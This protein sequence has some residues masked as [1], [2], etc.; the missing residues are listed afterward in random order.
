MCLGIVGR[1]EFARLTIESAKA[2]DPLTSK[3]DLDGI[4]AFV[5]DYEKKYVEKMVELMEIYEKPVVGVSLASSRGGTVRP[6][7]G[8]RYSGV[9]FKTPEKA[10]NVLASMVGY[11]QLVGNA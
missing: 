5:Y 7:S 3:E 9:F 6:I 4:E 8:S 2:V 1:V 11:W 10:V